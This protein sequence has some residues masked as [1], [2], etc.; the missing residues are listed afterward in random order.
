[1]NDV[2]IPIIDFIK[3]Y[4]ALVGIA[5]GYLFGPMDGLFIALILFV[6]ID[7]LT[8]VIVAILEKKLSSE[9]GFKGICKKVLIFILVALANIIDVYVMKCGA[10]V[11]TSV[12]FFYLANEG[13]SIL[14]NVSKTG[15]PV[16][17]KLRK[18]LDQLNKEDID[19]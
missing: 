19:E 3:Y 9:I 2:K 8:G 5:A 13:I 7:Y 16:P 4:A 11:R 6:I 17:E 10:A 18:I 1:M 12:I 15:L 14:E